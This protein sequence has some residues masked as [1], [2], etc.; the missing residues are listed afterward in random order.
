MLPRQLHPH[1]PKWGWCPLHQ[2]ESFIPRYSPK[3]YHFCFA[4]WHTPYFCPLSGVL[5]SR[6]GNS[7]YE[8]SS[9]DSLGAYSGH[10]LGSAL[11]VFAKWNQQKVWWPSETHIVMHTTGRILDLHRRS[12][13]WQ[14]SS[15]ISDDNKDG[16]ESQPSFQKLI[17]SGH[18]ELLR[19]SQKERYPLNP[20]LPYSRL[21][22]ILR[23]WLVSLGTRWGL[24]LIWTGSRATATFQFRPARFRFWL[25]DSFSKTC[26]RY[27]DSHN[28]IEYPSRIYIMFIVLVIAQVVVNH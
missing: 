5:F 25:V 12:R 9:R 10:L 20:T 21:R 17:S 1:Q 26:C 27:I 13:A 28:F 19:L 6:L 3:E 18:E 8:V 23:D 2:A 11:L 15:A 4:K 22:L 14:T 7:I 24:Y 16:I